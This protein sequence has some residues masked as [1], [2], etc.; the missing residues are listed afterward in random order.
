MPWPYRLPFSIEI[1]MQGFLGIKEL[2]IQ[3]YDGKDKY[4][5]KFE[6]NLG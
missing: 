4:R 6:E 3:R 2:F 5:V 1:E